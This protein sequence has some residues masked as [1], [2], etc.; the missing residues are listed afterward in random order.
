MQILK[1]TCREIKQNTLIHYYNTSEKYNSLRNNL[2]INFICLF[3]CLFVYL[4]VCFVVVFPPSRGVARAFPD[5]RVAQSTK[6]W[7]R[8]E[9]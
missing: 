3:D 1:I 2:F 9:N 4:F 6:M 8:K 5:G 7:K